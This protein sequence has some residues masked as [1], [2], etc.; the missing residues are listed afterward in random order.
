M[1]MTKF[2]PSFPGCLVV[3]LISLLLLAA[4]VTAQEASL[5]S[6]TETIDEDMKSLI[7][8]IKDETL[9]TSS[10]TARSQTT[11]VGES[12][13]RAATK[14]VPYP[15]G[16]TGAPA[17]LIRLSPVDYGDGISTLAGST[18]PSPREISNI[19]VDQPGPVF[20]QNNASDMVWQWGQFV[21]HD[22]DL[23]EAHDPPEPAPIPVPLG[24]PDFDPFSS[25]TQV[26]PL[27]RSIY[28]PTTG[29]G[30]GN[31]RQQVN[32]IS[33]PI[34]GT[35]VYGQDP[36]RTLALRTL[37]GTGRL[38]TSAG[39]FLPYN[40]LGLPN[41]IPTGADPTDFFVAGD[42]RSNEQLGLTSMH[43]LW[44]REHN[45]IADATRAIFPWLSGNQVFEIARSTV[46]T[47][48]QVITFNEFLPTLLGPN[49]ISAYTGYDP[50]VDPGIA[51]E[52]STALFRLGHTMLSP[53]IQRLEADGTPIPDGPIALRDAF[54]TPETLVTEGG[55]DPILKGLS[56]QVMQRIDN[57]IIDD[58]R[59]FLFG[60]PGAGGLDLAS[61]NIQRG[62]DH[63]IADYNTVRIHYGLTPATS[64]A[65]ISSDPAVQ[66]RL[67]AAYTSVDE[68]DLWVGAI[69]EDP[70]G[71]D[72]LVG[73]LLLTG[74]V[75]QF[76]RLRDGDPNWYQNRLGYLGQRLA[77]TQTLAK[78]IARNTTLR[79][80][81]L[82]RNVF[83]VP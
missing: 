15:V 46:V 21:D 62:R 28:D 43:T 13:S 30:V 68:V 32:E 42:I 82:Q 55:I 47:E 14:S 67:A 60:P 11:G 6:D 39:N 69:S 74:L 45:L 78:V 5:S 18:R 52:F 51:T 71:P 58:L 3:S 53:T 24:D 75:E 1:Y 57:M 4:P 49:A 77:E 29:T 35:N 70:V 33:G 41:A 59:N 2:R 61:L 31:P 66:S 48:L 81:D 19:V 83:V 23:T 8:S 10:E 34:D 27:L 16:G 22:V 50:N 79:R 36:A 80:R 26:I 25:G 73:E 20:S 17:Q 56:S 12:S 54:N 64:F 44:V 65:D 76:E 63:G 7:E 40:T 38:K 72:S 37:D 9:A